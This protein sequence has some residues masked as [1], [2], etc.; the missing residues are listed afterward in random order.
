MRFSLRPLDKRWN[1]GY[2]IDMKFRNAGSNSGWTP[3][4]LSARGY[5]AVVEDGL[6]LDTDVLRKIRTRTPATMKDLEQ[7]SG[8]Q[9][10]GGWVFSPEWHHVG[11]RFREARF[12]DPRTLNEPFFSELVELV[13]AARAERLEATR[14]ERGRWTI[15]ESSDGTFEI[16][17]EQLV[18]FR[19]FDTREAAQRHLD[20]WKGNLR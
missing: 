20:M 6:V 3:F 8:E 14:K 12:F 16:R 5:D 1:T 7:V 4:G 15:V 13:K 19:G 11:P 18:P 9:S 17:Y 10:S 2:N